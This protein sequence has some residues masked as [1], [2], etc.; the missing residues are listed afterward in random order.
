MTVVKNWIK[1]F[2]MR[3]LP[4]ALSSIILGGFLSARAEKLNFLVTALAVITTIFLQILSNLANDFGDFKAGT[5][6]DERTGPTRSVQGGDITENNMKKAIYIFIGLSFICGSLLIY[7][8]TLEM[9][10]VNLITFFF[11]GILAIAAA[12]NYTMGNNPYGYKGYGDFFVLVFF[13]FVGV[14]GTYYLN[15]H[16][17]DFT[18]T[19]P[20]FSV[21]L[22]SMAVLNLNNMRDIENDRN[23]GK[24][25]LVVKY[26]MK[27]SKIYHSVI[28]ILAI[29]LAIKFNL[30][31]FESYYQFIFLITIPLFLKDLISIV[32]NDKP[33]TLDPFLKKQAINTLLFSITFGLGLIL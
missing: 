22:L 8:G 3:T 27:R 28:I 30:N 25:T 11:I 23:S 26:G 19:L 10:V 14:I 17:I 33:E 6:N 1:A 5:D 9:S 13:G 15:A 32:K 31:H 12:V 20:A 24:H 4:L 7:F 18:L 29:A 2:R 21:G 16:E